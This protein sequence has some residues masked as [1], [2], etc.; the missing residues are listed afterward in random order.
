MK[1]DECAPKP[2]ELHSLVKKKIIDSLSGENRITIVVGGTGC[3]KSTLIPQLLLESIGHPILCTQ[4]RRLAVVAVSGHVA[5]QRNCTLG[6]EVGYHVGQSR[7]ATN[8]TKLLFATAGILLED[9]KAN[10]LDAICK[11]KVVV[12]DECHERS[13]ESDLCLV[14][15]KAF[16]IRYPQAT[17]KIILM[18]ATF[19]QGKY[20]SYFDGIPGC[21]C[22]NTIT[23]ETA[24]SIDAY[25]KQVKTHYMEDILQKIP[26]DTRRNHLQKFER[27]LRLDPD[28]EMHGVDGGKSLSADMLIVI[29]LLV[30]AL[31]EEEPIGAKFLIFVPTYRHLEQI[32]SVLTEITL[33]E[34]SSTLVD[35]LH[36]SVD[37]EDCLAKMQSVSNSG[38]TKNRHILLASAIADSSVTIPE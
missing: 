38:E 33:C 5:N 7:I 1:A 16:M 29:C 30:V 32:H 27:L 24:G 15:I 19:N 4:P 17:M 2:V 21:D 14:I 23:L 13:A 28:A 18:S 10:G 3:G 20:V 8:K 9:L 6:L 22:I 34:S 31:H 35:V 11:Y 36:S 12:I 25:Y 26:S 37:I